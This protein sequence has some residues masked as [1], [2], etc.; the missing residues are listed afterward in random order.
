MRC[1]EVVGVFRYGK[2][3]RPGVSDLDLLVVVDGTP[4]DPALLS[5]RRAFASNPVFASLLL[6]DA[7][8]LSCDDFNDLEKFYYMSSLECVAGTDVRPERLEKPWCDF[9]LASNAIDFAVP[10]MHRLIEFAH[11]R[12]DP[13]FL[14]ILSY[15]AVHTCNITE[16][17]CPGDVRV[18]QFVYSATE[19]RKTGGTAETGQN[20]RSFAEEAFRA[21]AACLDNIGTWLGASPSPPRNAALVEGERRSVTLF[22]ADHGLPQDPFQG[23]QE[24]RVFV[25]PSLFWYFHAYAFTA[26]IIADAVIKRL[27]PIPPVDC[28]G[29]SDAYLSFIDD[30]S[31][32]LARRFRFL[33]APGLE[34]SDMQ[35]KP[36]FLVP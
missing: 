30:R 16:R 29:L 2:V 18:S 25:H 35:V 3:N 32:V 36:G 33:S 13:S 22:A 9:A 4:R 14:M 27:S 8:V 24:S 34:F 31:R 7:A 28:S 6:H 19:R 1:P 5:A 26:T 17:M 23:N 12:Y 10:R 20:A 21:L 15:A 11:C